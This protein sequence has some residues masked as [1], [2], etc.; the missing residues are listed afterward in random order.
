MKFYQYSIDTKE[1]IGEIEILHKILEL[2][3]ATQIKPLKQKDSFAVCF[4]ENSQKWEYVEDNRNKTVYS[5]T[6]KE[7]LKVDYLGKIKNEHSLLVPKQ[8]DKWS[9][10]TQSWIEDKILK[11]EYL[12]IQKKAEKIEQL[13]T[14]VVTTSQGNIF[15][16]NETAR[17]NMVSAIQSA[18]LLGQISNNWKLADNTVKEISL[19]ELKEAL[20]LSIQKV[21]EIVTNAG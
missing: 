20:A 5:K 8:F 15:D 13:S 17:L 21:G 19:N 9:E 7:E 12:T 2:P 4:N 10:D 11:N 3:N 1:F 14:L 16:G 6:T 18:E